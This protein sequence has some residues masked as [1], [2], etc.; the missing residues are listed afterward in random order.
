MTNNNSPHLISIGID[1]GTKNG[2]IAIID[3]EL[4]IIYLAKTPYI[5][6]DIKSK[7]VKPK[8]NKETGKYETAYRQRTWVDFRNLREIFLPFL[9]NDIIFTTEKVK[10]MGEDEHTSSAF[11][12][13]HTLGVF[14]GQYSLLNPIAFYEPT[15]QV[16]KKEM[17][18]TA[19]KN[20]S[21]E[22]AEELF[23]CNLK[24][25]LSKRARVKDDNMA[26]ALLLAFY[27]LRM[28]FSKEDINNGSN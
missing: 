2:A 24:D 22:L 25:Y 10:S 13:G 7:K 3:D 9:D 14:Q 15:P 8:L 19:D 26:E 11:N 21:I 17:K 20:S 28:Y 12:F 5:S 6:V 23:K 1:P 4:N 16:W 18:V 27:G